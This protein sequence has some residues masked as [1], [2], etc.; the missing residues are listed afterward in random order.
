MK[1]KVLVFRSF[2]QEP[3]IIKVGIMKATPT[4]LLKRL[5]TRKRFNINLK[6][7]NIKRGCSSIEQL[8]YIIK[9]LKAIIEKL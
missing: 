8:P 5:L 9:Q 4:T 3:D 6:E 2:S 7:L 1:K